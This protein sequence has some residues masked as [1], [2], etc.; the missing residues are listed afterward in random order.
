MSG[1]SLLFIWGGQPDHAHDYPFFLLDGWSVLTPRKESKCTIS[2]V[3][4][5]NLLKRK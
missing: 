2:W 1:W 4:H 5:P 3:G